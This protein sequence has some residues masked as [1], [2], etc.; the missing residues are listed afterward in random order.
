MEIRE[1]FDTGKDIYRTIEKVITYGTAQEE[2]LKREISEYVVT[3]HIDTQ[4]H[5][6]LERIQQAMQWGGEHEVGVWVSGFYGSGKSSFT[7][8]LGF[9]LAEDVAI[10]GTPFRKYLRDRLRTPQAK[11][12]LDTTAQKFP[13]AIIMLD[14]ASEMVAGATMEDVATVLY[15]KV[16]QWAGY[17]RNLKVAALER[18][19]QKDGRYEEWRQLVEQETEMTWEDVQDDT[20]VIDSIVPELA[21]RIY[22]NLFRTENSFNTEAAEYVRFENERVAEM[23]DIVRQHSGREHIIFIIDEVGQYVGSRSNL[24]LNLDGLAKN[25][26]S[27]GDG[28]VWIIGTAQQTLTEDDPNA[29]LNSP[30]LY[31]LKD[32]FPIQ[33]NLQSRDIKEITI[34]RLL[35][36]SATGANRLGALFD[37]HGQQ[38]RHNIKLED[39]PA[40]DS[41]L[42]RKTFIDLYPF[43]PA[44]FD[45][46]LQMLAVLAKSTGGIGLRSAIK[47]IQDILIEGTHGTPAAKQEVGWLANAVTIYDTLSADI[48]AAMPS[49]YRSVEKVTNIRFPDSPIHQAVAKTVGLLKILDNMPVTRQNVA[50]LL[51]ASVTA[52]SQRDAVDAAVE[53][54][55]ADTIVPFGENDGNLTFFSEKLND[56]NGERGEIPLRGIE[57]RRLRNEA[58]KEL[59]RP[60]PSVRLANQLVVTTGLKATDGIQIDNLA[61]DNQT[62]QMMVQ[63]AP[64]ADMESV[65]QTVVDQARQPINNQIIYLLGRTAPA[66]EDLLGDIYRSREISKRYRSDPDQEVRDYATAQEDRAARQLRELQ[67]IFERQL[68][69]GS[70]VFRGQ[71]TAANTLAIDIQT[72]AKQLLNSAG[73]RV[74]ERYDEAPVRVNTDLAEKFLRTRNL[75]AITKELDPLDLVLVTGGQP[76]IDVD[77]RALVSI[78][79]L[80]EREGVVEGKRLTDIFTEAPYG[81]SPDTLRYLVSALLIA[82]EIRL[83]VAGRE[84]TTAGQQAIESLRT[85]NAFKKVGI[86]L[87]SYRPAP[88]VMARA[89][90]RLTEL[91]GQT[92]IPLEKNIGEAARDLIPKLKHRYGDLAERLRSL[93]LAGVGNAAALNETLADLMATDASEAPQQ[94]GAAESVLYERLRWARA[95]DKSLQ[96]GLDKTIRQL[97]RLRDQIGRLP[98]GGTPDELRQHLQDDLTWLDERLGQPS[99]YEHAADFNTRLTTMQAAIRDAARRFGAEQQETVRTVQQSLQQTHGWHELTQ[100][101]QSNQLGQL[102]NFMVDVPEDIDGMARLVNQRYGL[103]DLANRLR[104][105]ISDLAD[106]RRK[107]KLESELERVVREGQKTIKRTITVS[108]RPSLAEI[109]DLIRAL[110]KLRA[111]INLYDNIEI[112]IELT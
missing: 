23:I 19:L 99:F 38:L 25:L 20:L 86:G 63:L 47:V 68:L 65:R 106:E 79:D 69:A 61:G 71:V 93:A 42:D 87:R 91:S 1:L 40:Y 66:M 37:Q 18:R 90:E 44:H 43:L 45:I 6:L 98:S 112:T 72:A 95:V 103:Q 84:I 33:I 85:N 62:V 12:I 75:N 8:Y 82:S 53:D 108:P 7:K 111:E 102:E 94:F 58:L 5:R 10:E 105:E 34:E 107:E 9:A 110:E 101:E 30:E 70:F 48:E 11:A 51:Q 89:A 46:L 13:A 15:Y 92:V 41:E 67:T 109:N 64:P 88:E 50:G 36:K 96:N 56:I 57:L 74:Y 49:V 31:K 32:R 22:P 35:A 97:Q 76:R 80:I 16:L 52:V 14:L 78:R 55:L 83:K 3:E 2:R 59:F 24:I 100:E 39:A 77:H 73:E 54:L 27:I 60:L 4:F 28:K 26:R 21:H 29:A 81:W 17:S 104:Q